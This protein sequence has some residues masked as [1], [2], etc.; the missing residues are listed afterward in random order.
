MFGF[1]SPPL[2]G[3]GSP[4]SIGR[5]LK[6]ALTEQ[7]QKIGSANVWKRWKGDSV[8]G[9]LRNS[10]PQACQWKDWQDE[11]AFDSHM[12]LNMVSQA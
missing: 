12:H 3:W 11:D 6:E 10:E 4:R 2:C 7:K 5:L 9:F 8:K 1:F